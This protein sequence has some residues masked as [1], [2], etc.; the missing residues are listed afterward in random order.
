MQKSREERSQES[1]S[2]SMPTPSLKET[3]DWRSRASTLQLGGQWIK[4]ESILLFSSLSPPQSC[5]F[6]ILDSW[7]GAKRQG[8]DPE[9]HGEKAIE[10]QKRKGCRQRM[11]DWDRN[12]G[13]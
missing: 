8:T 10:P 9:S 7:I 6:G 5:S 12:K 2:W 4:W 1:Q 11:P 13:G 3:G